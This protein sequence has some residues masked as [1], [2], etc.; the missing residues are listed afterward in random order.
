MEKRKFII[1][2]ASGNLATSKIY[3]ALYRLFIRGI[4]CDYTGFGRTSFSNEEF[5][6]LVKRS[7]PE[8]I[9][10]EET[11]RD[12]LKKFSY[13]EGSYDKEGVKK[14]KKEIRGFRVTYYMA[15]PITYDL[16]K[17][18]L[19][20]LKENRLID[21]DAKIVLEKP[22]GTDYS[23]AQKLNLLLEKHFEERQIFRIDHYLAKDLVKNLFVL[24]FA[25]LI[26]EP[27]WNSKYIKAI[28]IS[29]KEETGIEERGEYYD[30]TGAIR[31]VIQNHLLQLLTLVTMDRPEDLNS[32]SIHDEKARILKKIRLFEKEGFKNIEIGQ[33]ESYRN[34]KDVKKGSLTETKALLVVEVNTERWRGV[35]IYLF[36]GKKLKEK[37]SDIE[38]EFKSE[39]KHLWGGNCLIPPENKLS[40]N[41]Q[42][43]YSVNFQLNSVPDSEKCPKPI[44]L[45]FSFLESEA[46][47]K[48]AYENALFDLY[49]DDRSVF[50][51][52]DEILYSWEFI[53][54]VI[55]K[56]NHKRRELLKIY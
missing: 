56:I 49:Q 21:K 15:I 9:W 44:S 36:T 24:R 6:N 10:N 38:I 26:F 31:D 12:F 52:S 53:D 8:K 3:P 2:G 25:N 33:Y 48:D 35:P 19:S 23:S 28:R 34:E 32:A 11:A 54:S 50:L 1:F 14:L 13:V 55:K 17:R 7:L 42:P 43:E 27:V 47:I 45:R 39:E 37:T 20:G 18:V 41:I 51:G 5:R 22:F 30:Q 46:M 29:L 40:I 4:Y 16:I